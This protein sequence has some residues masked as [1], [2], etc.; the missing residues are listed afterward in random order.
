MA[1]TKPANDYSVSDAEK[2]KPSES[3]DVP[4][5]NITTPCEKS[6]RSTE[7]VSG[8]GIHKADTESP[9]TGRIESFGGPSDNVTE[10]DAAA[11]GGPHVINTLL[12]V[13][14]QRSTPISIKLPEDKGRPI[15]GACCFM[16][17]GELVL[18]DSYN[19]GKIKL[20]DNSLTLQ[21][22]KTFGCRSVAAVDANN[23][24]VVRS[25]E[26]QLLRMFPSFKERKVFAT[27]KTT[28]EFKYF[29]YNHVA[30]SGDEICASCSFGW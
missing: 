12:N 2:T 24:V 29:E 30:A 7:S 3:S 26:L 14:I 28:K 16:P 8:S 27:D 5:D 22:V 15:I 21:C 20:L 10:T 6:P 23:I 18:C 13:K 19:D 11:E 1:T 17:G 4:T 25:R 9:S